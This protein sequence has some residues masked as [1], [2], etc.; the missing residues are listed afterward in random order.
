MNS[1]S[2]VIQF[3]WN[4]IYYFFLF[5]LLYLLYH[6]LNNQNNKMSSKIEFVYQNF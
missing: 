6:P 1:K 3:M 5:I 4:I 2:G